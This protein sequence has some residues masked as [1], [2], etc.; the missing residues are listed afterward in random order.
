MQES[1]LKKVSNKD[2]DI[3]L[4]HR[5]QKGDYRAFD[6]LIL[7]YQARVITLANKFVNDKQIAEDIAQESFIKV[8]KSIGS[9]RGESAFFTWL[10]RVAVN[11]AKNYL[12]SKKRK[13]EMLVSDITDS[14]TTDP[15]SA[16]TTESPE[17]ILAANNLREIILK[18]FGDLPEE[19]RTALS[20]RE[21]E[22]LSYQEIG[23]IL[24]CPVGTVRSRIFRGRE[25]IQEAINHLLPSSIHA[26]NERRKKE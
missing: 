17:D 20:L 10:Y 16:L 13:K 3:A 24:D 19:I 2:E 8:Y 21:F 11:T 1:H 12:S 25:Q 15:L 18:S 7:K 22:G 14:D 23:K 4:V 26:G 6:L 9:F 5:A